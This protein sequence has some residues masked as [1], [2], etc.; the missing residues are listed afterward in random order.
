LITTAAPD[1]SG[2]IGKLAEFVVSPGNG[3]DR[4]FA[5]RIYGARRIVSEGVDRIFVQI[6]PAY[7]AL[8]YGRA[9][10]FVQDKTSLDIF[11]AMT[12]DTAGLVKTIGVNPTP[13]V[14]GY[15]VRYDET[16]IDYLA[17]LLAQ[18]GITYFFVYD[19]ASGPFRHKMIVTNRAADYIDIAGSPIDFLP[20]SQKGAMPSLARD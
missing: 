13:A 16:E 6:R 8:S 19:K 4:T 18:D 15:S 11:E 14:R 5:G 2:W 9:T 7:F 12:A 17:R 1:L 20:N 3:S 10:H